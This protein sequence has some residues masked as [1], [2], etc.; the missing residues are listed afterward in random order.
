[1][2]TFKVTT[3]EYLTT[4]YRVKAEDEFHALDCINA[5][6]GIIEDTDTRFSD[7]EWEVEEIKDDE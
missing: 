5:G 4:T 2:K 1:M 3:L 7:E 6:E